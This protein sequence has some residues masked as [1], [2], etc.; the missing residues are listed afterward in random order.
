MSMGIISYTVGSAHIFVALFV[1]GK[2]Y[3]EHVNLSIK[4]MRTLILSTIDVTVQLYVNLN[5]CPG[6]K[7]RPLPRKHTQ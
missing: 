4:F 2:P 6:N 1:Q 5:F 3:M 7:V